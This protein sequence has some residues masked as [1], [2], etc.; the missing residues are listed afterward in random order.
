MKLKDESVMVILSSPSGAGKTTLTKKIQQKY[1]NFKIS[2]SH[3]TRAPRPNEVEGVD[4]FF[5]SNT[6]F[7]ELVKKEKFYEHA[8][9]FDNY[10]GTS[11]KS[12]EDIIKN[13]NDLLFDIDWQGTKQLSEFT[14]LK[15][16]KIFIL[17]PNKKELE[18]RLLQRN[19]DKKQTVEKRL[20]SY[21]EDITHWSDYDYVVINDNLE[22][23]FRQIEKII[24]EKKN[25]YLN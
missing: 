24:E 4:Y 10:Y 3:T 5:I 11:K 17:P 18:K 7:N 21:D 14:E 23:C 12:V 16:I 13:H 2:V 20:K 25:K 19:Q 15:L 22:N 1:Q 6:K 9:I 8:K